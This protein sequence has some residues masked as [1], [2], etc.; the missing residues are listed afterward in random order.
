MLASGSIGLARYKWLAE[1]VN[2]RPEYGLAHRIYRRW[3][4]YDALIFLKS[5]GDRS[6]DLVR[7]MQRSRRPVVFDA[8]VNYYSRDGKEY[9]ERMLPSEKQRD[10]A[11]EVT[12][13][14]DAVIADS[15]YI[16]AVC[17]NY[18][19]NVEWIPDN[20]RM[21]LVPAYQTWCLNSKRLQ[22]LWC[23]EAVKLFELLVIKKL[24]LDFAD[25]IELIL[26]TNDFAA[27]NRWHGDYKSQ[28]QALLDRVPHRIIAYQSIEHLF[29]IYASGGVFISPRFLDN[30]Y[31]LGHTEWKI[32]LAMA[33]SRLALC[34]PLPSYLDVSA[35]AEGRGIR[36]C[37]TAC[38]WEMALDTI[39]KNDLDLRSEEENARAVVEQYYSTR[40]VAK[41]HTAFL[42]K[43]LNDMLPG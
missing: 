18:N 27:L 43:V 12:T 9:Y 17:Q 29:K 2:A 13:A 35:K 14:S 40:V 24:L 34:S 42:Q 23:G 21:D 28:F 6:M 16:K 33:C 30:S 11:I 15:Q 31:N 7:K 32:T 41:Y 1:Y 36:I 22:L 4:N 26:I 10:D 3:G 25:R 38:D 5:M 39:L 8:N 37:G 20:V 19:A